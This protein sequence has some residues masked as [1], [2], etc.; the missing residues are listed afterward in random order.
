[1]LFSGQISILAQNPNHKETKQCDENEQKKMRAK[2]TFY[3][4]FYGYALP[5]VHIK[6]PEPKKKVHI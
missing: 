1:L 2:I 5:I 6:I 4:G 3:D